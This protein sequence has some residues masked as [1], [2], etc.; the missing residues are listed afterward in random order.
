MPALQAQQDGVCVILGEERGGQPLIDGA[1][2][3]N[4]NDVGDS[5]MGDYGASIGN[6][7]YELILREPDERLAHRS[8]AD[9]KLFTEIVLNDERAAGI[10]S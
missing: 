6:E 2:L 10:F 8:P 3:Q 4:L 5:E 1:Q 9:G 7:L